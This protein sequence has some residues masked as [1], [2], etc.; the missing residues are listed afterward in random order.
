MRVA[1]TC[2]Y[3]HLSNTEKAVKLVYEEGF[4]I[5]EVA[6]AMK[7]S[8]GKIYRGKIAVG[9]NREV[10]VSGKPR[11]LGKEGE[12]QLVSIISEADNARKP[13]KY[14]DVKLKVCLCVYFL[15]VFFFILLHTN[16]THYIIYR[17]ETYISTYLIKI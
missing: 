3:R 12:A 1:R 15:F 16:T 14:S 9:E 4:G 13:L 8:K 6:K 2:E 5:N 11:V 7:V 17:L 10:G